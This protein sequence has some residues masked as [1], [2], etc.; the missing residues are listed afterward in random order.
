MTKR[1]QKRKAELKRLVGIDPAKGMV[2]FKT[3]VNLTKKNKSK[4]RGSKE[5]QKNMQK[6]LKSED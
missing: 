3:G 5:H 1:K 4:M 6:D 2:S